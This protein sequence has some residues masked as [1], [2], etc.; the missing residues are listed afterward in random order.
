MG[1]LGGI[2][3]KFLASVVTTL[4]GWFGIYKM[5]QKAQA[6][7]DQAATLAIVEKER[8][9]ADTA[10]SAQKAAGEGKF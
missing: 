9:A 8:D 4:L 7:K 1:F 2:L 5:G 3:G 10:Q 6:E